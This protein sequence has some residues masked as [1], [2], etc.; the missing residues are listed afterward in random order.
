ME[1]VVGTRLDYYEVMGETE[2]LTRAGE[3]D[4]DTIYL[5]VNEGDAYEKRD[6]HYDYGTNEDLSSLSPEEI[7]WFEQRYQP[8]LKALKDAYGDVQI[9]WGVHY[10][11]W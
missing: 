7:I 3:D 10:Y 11:Q 1:I 8:E 2:R 6:F 5:I 4:N 9:R